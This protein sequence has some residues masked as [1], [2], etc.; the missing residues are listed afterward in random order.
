MSQPRSKAVNPLTSGDFS[1]ATDPWELFQS[2]F[3][4]AVKGEPR[5]PTAMALATVDADGAPNV[6]IVLMKGFDAQGFVFYTN[7]ES[8]KGCELD[9]ARKAAIAFY[10]KSLNRQVRDP[11]LNRAGHRR[12]GRR[13]LRHA[14][15]WGA[16][17][18]L[19]QRPVAR[20][21]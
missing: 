6:R 18:R 15:L 4:D 10:W 19:G 5:D 12:R 1:G 7:S 17:R 11:R 21:R 9:A 2:W 20:P 8:A 16:H 3:D 14:P 13:L